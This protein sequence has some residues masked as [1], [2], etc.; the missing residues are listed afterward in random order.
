MKYYEKIIEQKP[1]AID[2]LNAGHVAWVMGDIQK[3]AVLY[4]KAI[5]ACHTRNARKIPRNVSSLKTKNPLKNLKQGIF[6]KR[7]FR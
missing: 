7:I 3:A 5:T 1:L 4:G 2:Y 6:E